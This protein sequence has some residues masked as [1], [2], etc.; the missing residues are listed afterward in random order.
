MDVETLSYLPPWEWPPDSSEAIIDALRSDVADQSQRLLAAQ[1]AGESPHMGDELA[2][3]LLAVIRTPDE[4][5]AIRGA[6][7]ISL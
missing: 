2:E 3:A 6:A 5:D 1:L 4:A 7:A